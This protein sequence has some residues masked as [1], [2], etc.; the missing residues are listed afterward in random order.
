MHTCSDGSSDETEADGYATP[1]SAGYDTPRSGYST[2]GS[3]H[4]GS[5]RSGSVAGA[6]VDV[7]PYRLQVVGHSLGAASVLGYAVGRRMLGQPHRIR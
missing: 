4:S 1:H 7:T 6:E 3:E 5:M 2:P